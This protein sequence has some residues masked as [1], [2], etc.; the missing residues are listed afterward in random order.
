[1]QGRPAGTKLVILSSIRLGRNQWVDRK[2]RQPE[3]SRGDLT[4]VYKLAALTEPHHA[5]YEDLFLGLHA[6]R[7]PRSSHDTANRTTN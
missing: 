5:L 6:H 3:R 4:E 1:M 2:L 7:Q